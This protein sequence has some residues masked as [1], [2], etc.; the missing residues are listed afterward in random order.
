VLELLGY[1]LIAIVAA[2]VIFY[3]AVAFLPEGLRVAPERDERPFVLP[4]DRRMV[5]GDLDTVRIPV[6]VRG[7]RFAETDALI[8]RL[9]AEIHVRDEELASLRGQTDSQADEPVHRGDD[10]P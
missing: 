3:L 2:A 10:T 5:S 8:D 6:A 7:Y 9:A 4:Q 1:V